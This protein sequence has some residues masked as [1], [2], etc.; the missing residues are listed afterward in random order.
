MAEELGFT[1]EL[2]GDV[3]VIVWTGDGC[4]PATEPE[5][6]MWQALRAQLPRSEERRVG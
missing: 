4:R 1:I 3:H 5:V 6:E 2:R